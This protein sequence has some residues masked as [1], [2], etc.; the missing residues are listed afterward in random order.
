MVEDLGVLS[1]AGRNISRRKIRAVLVI[2]AL[3]F[4]MAI[5]ISIPAGVMATQKATEN[6][7]KNLTTTITR[8]GESIN[9]TLKQIDC[10]LDPYLAGYGTKGQMSIYRPGY[11]Q[12]AQEQWMWNF[13]L[14][15]MPFLPDEAK[16]T[17]ANQLLGGEG[18]VPMQASLYS[19]VAS[20][21][22]VAATAQ[23]LQTTQGHTVTEY[24]LDRK[25][26]RLVVEYKIQGVPLISSLLDT[27]PIL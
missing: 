2:V 4:S 19:D 6:L 24:V 3:G 13:L 16:N 8:T 26:D 18:L 5:M 9:R 11:V 20:I 23:I 22:G 7:T 15:Y 12:T 25:F 10:A 1:R 21:N 14:Q 17:M 27:Y